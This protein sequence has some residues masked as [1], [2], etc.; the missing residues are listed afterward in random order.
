MLI[1]IDVIKQDVLN[2]KKTSNTD[3]YKLNS[4][5]EGHEV[6]YVWS[7]IHKGKSLG[8]SRARDVELS[9]AP[10]PNIGPLPKSFLSLKWFISAS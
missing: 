4:S 8:K 5:L 7:S 6:P 9:V 3:T 1:L 2:M 10:Y